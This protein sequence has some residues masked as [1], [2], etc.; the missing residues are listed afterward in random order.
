MKKKISNKISE[1]NNNKI[2]M[3][4]IVNT[5]FIKGGAMIVTFLSMPAYLNYFNNNLILGFWFTVLSVLT[6][7]LSFDLGIGN[8]LRNKLVKSFVIKDNKAIKNYI[9][10]AYIIIGLFTIVAII[11][12]NII[13]NFINW[14]FIFKIPESLIDNHVLK[15]VMLILVLG[16]LI[17]IFLRLINSILYA[18]QKSFVNNLNILISNIIILAFLL[19]INFGEIIANLYFISFVYIFSINIP[20]LI[21]TIVVFKTTLIDCKPNFKNY[22]RVHATSILKLGLIFFWVQVMY[23]LLTT[24]NEFL[25]SW[26]SQTDKVVEFQVYNRV[27]TL[28]G[29]IFSLTLIPIWSIVT[30]AFTERNFIWIKK[31]YNIFVLLGVVVIILEFSIVP[32]LQLILDVWLQDKS[33]KVNPFYAILFAVLGSMI[34]W[35]GVNNNFANG[36]GELKTQ[37]ILFTF[38]VIIKVP[39]SWYFVSVFESWIGVVI[40]SILSL[41]VYCVVQPIWLRKHLNNLIK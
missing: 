41:S 1:V 40:A 22:S 4:N 11:V 19:I 20:I 33:I 28:L 2:I 12:F 7:I 14:N 13:N 5:F 3:K 38:G 34:V 9:S 32:F 6:W 21:S 25:I 26:F 36:L 39:L 24:T 16:I 35:I 18:M 8:G 17:Q 27:F 23:M 10:S 30:K 31:T 37:T 29:T 15:N